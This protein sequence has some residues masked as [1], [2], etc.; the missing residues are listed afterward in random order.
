MINSDNLQYNLTQNM[1]KPIKS[2]YID[3]P[4]IQDVYLGALILE[5][6]NEKDYKYI[7]S[8]IP[9]YKKRWKLTH[10][11]YFPELN[12][13]EEQLLRYMKNQDNA[14]N[15]LL[16]SPMTS[17]FRHLPDFHQDMTNHTKKV[18]A[19]NELPIIRYVI[20]VH[21][22]NPT[23]EDLH[24]IH[25]RIK[26]VAPNALV[27]FIKK[28]L[29]DVQPSLYTDND[30]WF[31][32]DMFPLMNVERPAGQHFAKHFSFRESLIFSPRRMGTPELL[33]EFDQFTEKELHTLSIQT[34][35]A[36]NLYSDFY[37]LD[38]DIKT[39]KDE[40]NRV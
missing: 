10:A 6:M 29:G 32:Y 15:I 19:S 40:D 2:V 4:Y 8:R 23:N 1:L 27:G 22:L 39:E 35:T 3:L 34:A 7:Y 26:S 18:S 21:P 31:I 30:I 5:H 25:E 17:L 12:Y 37:Y 28:S 20:N 24:I 9:E 33:Q 36:L 13:T 11:D 14:K 38:I 16:V